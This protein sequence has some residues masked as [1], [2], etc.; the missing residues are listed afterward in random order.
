MT[1]TNMLGHFVWHEL[2]TTNTRAA[3]A[4]YRKVAAWT[5]QTS[6]QH[7]SYTEFMAGGRPAAGLMVLPEPAK[8]MGAPPN[9]LTYVATPD[10]EATVRKAVKMGA[11]VL[12]QA[13]D[14]PNV[15]RFAVLQDPHG[16]VFAAITLLTPPPASN[17]PPS[18]GDFSWH[19][20]ATTDGAAAW[21]FY[22]RL[23]GW[24]NTESMDMGP[25]GTY[26]MFGHGGGSVGGMFT[27]P[28]EAPGPAAW[29][30]YIKVTDSKAVAA[31]VAGLGGQV[32]NGPM[33]V[34]GGDWIVM[35]MDPQGAVFAT[36][37]AKLA[38]AATKKTPAR[39]RVKA[40]R[41]A[42]RKKAATKAPVRPTTRTTARR[43]ARKTAGKTALKT[44]R[45]K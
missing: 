5:T 15:G 45:K 16:A 38:A 2:M 42:A 14:I 23:F 21:R 20:L 7:S 4:F 25:M 31:R 26:Q 13:T 28:K 32:L 33:E 8:A 1:N 19:E 39:K 18:I 36:H 37:S 27:K 9:W 10:V 11:R 40:A 34:P 30:P 44:A 41:P 35:G 3:A 22:S 29:V 12:T 17:T 6:P 43:G 24:R